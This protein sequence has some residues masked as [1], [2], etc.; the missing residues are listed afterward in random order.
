MVSRVTVGCRAPLV[1]RTS[2]RFPL[3]RRG[4][5]PPGDPATSRAPCARLKAGRELRVQVRIK[6]TKFEERHV[7]A[8]AVAARRREPNAARRGVVVT[9]HTCSRMLSSWRPRLECAPAA[10]SA[11][12]QARGHPRQPHRSTA[13]R[14]RVRVRVTAHAEPS[15]NT[16]SMLCSTGER[17]GPTTSA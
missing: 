13:H 12:P 2:G 11:R 6:R 9:L 5:R 14:V 4:P 10:T 16:W 15:P 8:S 3:K 7:S 17:K 1:A